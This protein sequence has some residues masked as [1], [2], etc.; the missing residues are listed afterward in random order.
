MVTER[1]IMAFPTLERSIFLLISAKATLK[2][3]YQG[4]GGLTSY[5]IYDT[6]VTSSKGGCY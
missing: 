2:S 3:L 1:K 5:P 4:E 6:I